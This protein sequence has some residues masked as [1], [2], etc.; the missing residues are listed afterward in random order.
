MRYCLNDRTAGNWTTLEGGAF[1]KVCAQ[2]QTEET[3][4]K[5]LRQERGEDRYVGTA[6]VSGPSNVLVRVSI[7]ITRDA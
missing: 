3:K 6:T 4:K 2:S 1:E 7:Y 5:D